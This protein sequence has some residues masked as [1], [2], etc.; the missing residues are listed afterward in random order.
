MPI[1][2][3]HFEYSIYLMSKCFIKQAIVINAA[4]I[5]SARFAGILKLLIRPCIDNWADDNASSSISFWLKRDFGLRSCA[6]IWKAPPLPKRGHFEESRTL[7]FAIMLFTWSS[8]AS[9]LSLEIGWMG[10]LLISLIYMFLQIKRAGGVQ[11]QRFSGSRFHH[12]T[13]AFRMN[14]EC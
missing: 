12:W 4:G 3:L 7:F 2:K 8:I 13:K 14:T 6:R 1:F 10:F 9:R 11:R 5:I